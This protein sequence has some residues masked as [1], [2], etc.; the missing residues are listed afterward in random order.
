VRV[1]NSAATV[2]PGDAA[3]QCWIDLGSSRGGLG[4]GR[5]E[6]LGMRRTEALGVR[7]GAGLGGYGLAA[8]TPG[9]C[10]EKTPKEEEGVD[11]G[12]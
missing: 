12:S 8:G 6:A 1:S 11:D 2:R 9:S 4:V 7:K 10:Q 5:T 3:A